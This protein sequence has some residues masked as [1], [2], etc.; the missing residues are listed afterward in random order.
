MIG[1][2]FILLCLAVFCFAMWKLWGY[3][4]NYH[5]GKKEYQALREYVTDRDQ[6]QKS[7]SKKDT[8]PVNVDF[9]ALAKVNSDVKAWIYIEGT[10]VNY[11]IVQAKDNTYYL[12]RTFEKRDSYIGAIFLDEGCADDFTSE[13]SIVYGHNLKNGEMFGMLK[14]HY[15]TSYNEDA[16]YKKH[17]KIWIITPEEEIEYQLF[18]ARELD[19]NVEKNAYM[20]SFAT[21]EDR[22]SYIESAQKKSLYQTQTK[23]DIANPIL[24][25]STCTSSSESGRFIIQATQIQRTTKETK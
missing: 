5:D 25:L 13:N 4:K 18:A 23:V 11:P 3:Y 6:T 7:K 12:H 20:I 14:K 19:V 1:N 10:G 16:D 17:E 15:D 22:Q 24:T 21:A 8:C 9:D 2:F